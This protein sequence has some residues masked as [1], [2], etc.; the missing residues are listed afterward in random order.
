MAF[1]CS[2]K[3]GSFTYNQTALLLTLW[4]VTIF[5]QRISGAHYNPALSI[6]HML[7]KD[8]GSFPRLLAFAYVLAQILGGFLGAVVSWFLIGSF[9]GLKEDPFTGIVAPI[10]FNKLSDSGNIYPNCEY[11]LDAS[12]KTLFNC[13]PFWFAA[14]WT[15]LIG[16][17]FLSFFFL[18]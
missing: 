14:I 10:T 11:E 16:S 12:N 3:V 1:N 13:S 18:T 15:E 9:Y 2:Q 4:V 8:V 7:R 17:F 5:G 6:A